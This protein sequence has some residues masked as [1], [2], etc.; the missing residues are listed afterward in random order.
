MVSAKIYSFT[1][2]CKRLELFWNNLFANEIKIN[3]SPAS[4]KDVVNRKQETQ[5]SNT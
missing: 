4:V 3:E 1:V 2:F 5:N